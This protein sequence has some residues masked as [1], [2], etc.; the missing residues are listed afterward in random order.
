YF[1][2][3]DKLKLEFPGQKGESMRISDS[4]VMELEME[5]KTT[6]RVLERI[7]EDK[8]AWKPHD[9]SMT[10]GQLASH[11]AGVQ[12]FLATATSVDTFDFASAGRPPVA[13]SRQE[14]LDS[15][16]KGTEKAKEL[17]SK[18]YDAHLMGIWTATM[19]GKT[20]MAIPRIGAIRA[21]V[22]NHIYHH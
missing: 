18:M 22:L 21:L 11:I 17:I 20:L 3:D 13:N 10:L 7:P 16:T 2:F 1:E 12:G 9:T 4:I 5:A 8:L 15:H 14:I 6:R 19:G